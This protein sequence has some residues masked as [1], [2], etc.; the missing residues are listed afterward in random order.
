MLPRLRSGFL[1]GVLF[2]LLI[3]EVKNR[4]LENILCVLFPCEK[5]AFHLV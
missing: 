5:D 3:R 1:P 4:V 2:W